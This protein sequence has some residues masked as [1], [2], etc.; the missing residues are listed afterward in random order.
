MCGD[1]AV[2]LVLT[3]RTPLSSCSSEAICVVILLFFFLWPHSPVPK[4]LLISIFV[5]SYARY[6]PNRHT[7]ASRTSCF[8]SFLYGHTQD[9]YQITIQSRA[10][11]HA[12]QHFCV[13]IRKIFTKSPYKQGLT[14]ED[15]LVAVW[16]FC[17]RIH[18]HHTAICIS[19][20][21]YAHLMRLMYLMCFTHLRA[22]CIIHIV[23]L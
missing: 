2:T 21:P 16:T 5:W 14:Y 22:L 10:E 1:L 9:V 20:V 3:T 12:F 4:A 11:H 19:H 18:F 15:W 7:I 6:L 23:Q 17:L 8:S 13:V